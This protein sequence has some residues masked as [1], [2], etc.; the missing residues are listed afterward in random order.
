MVGSHSVNNEDGIGVWADKLDISIQL[1]IDRFS[2]FQA[3]EKVFFATTKGKEGITRA[4]V[5]IL[6]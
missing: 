6:N 4:F 3:Q 1:V 2:T 5:A